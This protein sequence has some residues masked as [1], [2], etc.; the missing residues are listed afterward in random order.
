MEFFQMLLIFKGISSR[1]L[2]IRPKMKACVDY[3]LTLTHKLCYDIDGFLRHHG[4]Q[5]NQLLVS[6]FLHD[7]SFLQECL[8]GHSARLQRLYRHL[9]ST[10]PRS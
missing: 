4:I 3:M 2:V 10:V 8:W 5:L 7:L 6:Q 9:C 1:S